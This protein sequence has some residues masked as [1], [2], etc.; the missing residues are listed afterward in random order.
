MTDA[1]HMDQA[2]ADGETSQSGQA[3][4]TTYYN[5]SCPVCRTE[6]DHYRRLTARDGLALSWA[7]SS[8][9]RRLLEAHGIAPDDILKRLYVV[10][11]E[12]RL[13]GGI[14]AFLLIWREIPAY[15]WLARVIGLPGIRHAAGF[16]YDY[17]VAPAI[18]HWNRL[19]GRI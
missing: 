15:R 8:A 3:C 6:I 2:S 9:D 14:D 5:A 12:G 18:F 17:A 10:D 11:R 16:A 1:T 7:D 4:L 13:H 19:G